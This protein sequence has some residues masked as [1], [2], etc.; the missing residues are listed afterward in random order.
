MREMQRKEQR[1]SQNVRRILKQGLTRSK[2]G[3]G[4]HIK[5]RIQDTK[6]WNEK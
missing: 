5:G 3:N 4:R 1:S 2:R 6:R